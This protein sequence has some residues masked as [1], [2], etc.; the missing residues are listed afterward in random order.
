MGKTPL[1][2]SLVC[3][4]LYMEDIF[5]AT[6]VPLYPFFQSNYDFL[7]SLLRTEITDKW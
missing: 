7:I 1:Q 2:E 4:C 3:E 5:E 6:Y